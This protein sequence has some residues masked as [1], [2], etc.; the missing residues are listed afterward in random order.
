VIAL[1]VALTVAQG[2]GNPVRD[3]DRH[4]NPLQ[5]VDKESGEFFFADVGSESALLWKGP[6]KMGKDG[7][8][9]NARRR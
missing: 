5:N 2:F 8:P 7:S 6:P 4:L 9:K 3:V 1:L